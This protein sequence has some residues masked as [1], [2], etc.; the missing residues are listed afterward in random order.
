MGAGEAGRQR[1]APNR[2]ATGGTHREC[3]CAALPHGEAPSSTARLLADYHSPHDRLPERTSQRRRRWRKKREPLRKNA[4]L[5]RAPCIATVSQS[6]ASEDSL[7]N[8]PAPPSQSGV[9][10]VG[11]LGA[12][13][14][15]FAPSVGTHAHRCARPLGPQA[16]AR[17]GACH[18][19]PRPRLDAP[20]RPPICRLSAGPSRSGG[21][22][23]TTWPCP[24][25][26]R[27]G[28][29][30]RGRPTSQSG[31]QRSRTWV[32][33]G[34]PLGRAAFGRRHPCAG[35]LL[36]PAGRCTPR[37][38]PRAGTA[39]RTAPWWEGHGPGRS[40]SPGGGC[41]AAAGRVLTER[42]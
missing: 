40:F 9:M 34:R 6:Y 10:R 32:R 19:T 28:R 18:G 33:S 42:W 8:G 5:P 14:A 3:P 20:V 29:L 26:S 23:R 36:A 35:H 12:G 7:P 25:R 31:S 1:P 11:G 16:F 37:A 27:G 13:D 41:P 24:C 30:P 39:C 4:V 17:D 38:L 15:A 22:P 21:L 2:A